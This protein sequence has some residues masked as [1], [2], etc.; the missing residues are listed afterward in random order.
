[1]Y[2]DVGRNF[3]QSLQKLYPIIEKCTHLVVDNI[4]KT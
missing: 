1:M 4:S 3:E 2:M